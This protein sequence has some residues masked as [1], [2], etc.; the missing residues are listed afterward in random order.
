MFMMG[1][2]VLDNVATM[3]V[4]DQYLTTDTTSSKLLYFVKGHGH[5]GDVVVL[6]GARG[7]KGV[8]SDKGPAGSLG[9]AG[10]R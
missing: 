10:K 3:E 8:P 2:Y 5:S 1:S 7:L 4:G 6:Q 9:P